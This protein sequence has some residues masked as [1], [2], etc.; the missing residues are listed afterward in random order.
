M[1]YMCC[2]H[3]A[4]KSTEQ[5]L[6]K[7]CRTAQLHALI[8]GSNISK[9]GKRSLVFTLK[10]FVEKKGESCTHIEVFSFLKQFSGGSNLVWTRFGLACYFAG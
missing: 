3:F 4:H 2:I 9:Y 10:S 5:C 1:L 7:S 8:E 6:F